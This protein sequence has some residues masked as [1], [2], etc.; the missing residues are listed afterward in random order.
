MQAMNLLNGIAL[1]ISS[2][3]QHKINKTA[4]PIDRISNLKTKIIYYKCNTARIILIIEMRE[5]KKIA[6]KNIIAYD[7]RKFFFFLDLP[8][9]QSILIQQLTQLSICFFF[10]CYF[11]FNR[12][13]HDSTMLCYTYFSSLL[14]TFAAVWPQANQFRFFCRCFCIVCECVSKCLSV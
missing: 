2:T 13:T 6:G 11:F 10:C 3:H 8:I 12:S 9:N 5:E 1:Q 4:I 7:I 14:S